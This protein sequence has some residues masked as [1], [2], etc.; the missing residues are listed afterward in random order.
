MKKRSE[1]IDPKVEAWLDEHAEEAERELLRDHPPSLLHNYTDFT[2]HE[3]A[4]VD[5]LHFAHKLQDHQPLL[6]LMAVPERVRPLVED[7][8]RKRIGGEP[9]RYLYEITEKEQVYIFALPKVRELV[10]S[11]LTVKEA[12]KRVI[13]EYGIDHILTDKALANAYSG[14]SGYSRKLRQ[15]VWDMMERDKAE[16]EAYDPNNDPDI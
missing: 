10:D 3:W 15:R 6:K 7:Y 16:F 14:R 1:K 13:A 5:A 9:G 8:F 4:W 2:G 11:G 12:A